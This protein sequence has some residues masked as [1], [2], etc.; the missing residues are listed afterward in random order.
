MGNGQLSEWQ[1]TRCGSEPI[2]L[3]TGISDDYRVGICS[4][5]QCAS[6]APRTSKKAGPKL[7]TGRG[8][9]IRRRS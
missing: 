4:N 9:F 7:A 2:E 1:C 6:R 5:Y 3:I 8:T